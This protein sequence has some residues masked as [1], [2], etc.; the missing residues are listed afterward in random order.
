MVYALTDINKIKKV[1]QRAARYVTNRRDMISN[2][3]WKSL[4][5]GRKDSGLVVLY[6][7]SYEQVAFQKNRQI[8]STIETVTHHAFIR[9]SNTVLYHH[10]KHNFDSLCQ[11]HFDKLA[12]TA[13]LKIFFYLI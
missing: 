6:K 7:F 4:A 2:L 8:N 9:I 10:V 11:N 1:Q 12:R 3:K 5:E 13:F